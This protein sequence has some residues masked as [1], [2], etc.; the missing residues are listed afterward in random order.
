MNGGSVKTAAVFATLAEATTKLAVK[1]GT[2]ITIFV[3]K[4]EKEPVEKMDIVFCKR[5]M[6]YQFREAF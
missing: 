5:M 2:F 3:L 4:M 6:Y 1:S